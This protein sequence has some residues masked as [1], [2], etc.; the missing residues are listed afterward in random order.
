MMGLPGRRNCAVRY[1]MKMRQ[2][3]LGDQRVAA[4]L[5]A[6][7]PA[8]HCLT[9][10]LVQ[11]QVNGG[12]VWFRTG[13]HSPRR[14]T[15]R[16]AVPRAWIGQRAVQFPGCRRARSAW[17]SRSGSPGSRP[18]RWRAYSPA[19]VQSLSSGA[20]IPMPKP[21]AVSWESAVGM[22]IPCLSPRQAPSRQDR[23]RVRYARVA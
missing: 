3:V 12:G 21:P 11:V 23:L 6:K 5:E 20:S 18:A 4:I 17:R 22:T 13:N 7:T 19:L 2:H 8:P 16:M 10:M 9:G 15:A 1:N 14:D